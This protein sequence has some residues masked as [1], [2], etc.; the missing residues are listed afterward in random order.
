MSICD[1]TLI[2]Q[3]ELLQMILIDVKRSFSVLWKCANKYDTKEC[4]KKKRRI[5]YDVIS[6]NIISIVFFSWNQGI[7][8]KKMIG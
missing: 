1:D 6:V 4:Y 5:A 7:K 2:T 3:I 8:N